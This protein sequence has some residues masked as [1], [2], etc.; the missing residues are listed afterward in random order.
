MSGR[1]SSVLSSTSHASGPG[2]N[3]SGGLSRVT[4]IRGEEIPANK[5]HIAPVSWWCIIIL[6]IYILILCVNNILDLVFNQLLIN[7]IFRLLLTLLI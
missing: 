1:Y 4:P 3:P 2:L 5:S 7:L 6:K